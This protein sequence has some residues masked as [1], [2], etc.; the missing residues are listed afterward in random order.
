[1]SPGTATGTP[2]QDLAAIASRLAAGEQVADIVADVCARLRRLDDPA[3][4]IGDLAPDLDERVT[5]LDSLTAA[6]REDLALFGVP[7]VV[8]DNIDVAGMP[9]TAACRDLDRTPEASAAAVRRLLDAGAVLVA[10]V[11]LD[12]FATGL[13][14]TRS[15]YGTPRNV[16]DPAVVPGGSSSGSA[17]AVAAGIVPFALGTDTAGSGRVPAA[18]NQVVGV[19]PTRGTISTAGVVPAVA[20]MDCISV[21]CTSVADGVAIRQ[22]LDGPDRGDPWRRRSPSRRPLV[23]TDRLRVGVPEPEHLHDVDPAIVASMHRAIEA[24]VAAGAQTEPVDLTLLVETGR[25]LYDGALV[26]ERHASVGAFVES[27]PDSVVEPTRTIITRAAEWRATDLHDLQHRLL[28]RRDELAALWAGVDLLVTPTVPS[29]PTLAAV[30]AD[31]VG[32]NAEL[33]RFT[34]FSNLL[35]LAVLALPDPSAPAP[36]RGVSLQGPAGSDDLLAAAASVVLGVTPSPLPALGCV[37]LA[38]VGAHLDG[39][40]LNHQ[41]TDRGA[42]LVGATTTS[43]EYRLWAL[44]D[45]VRPALQRVPSGGAPIE[46]EVWS[47]AETELGGFAAGITAPLGLGTVR[48]RDGRSVLG[49]IVEDGGLGGAV[50]ITAARGWRAYRRG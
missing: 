50:D 2:V 34:T 33:G 45:G 30:A 22:L 13:V 43:A 9:T 7:F 26:A 18:M 39:E 19:K 44:P 41:L 49:F 25:Q 21:F 4:V 1:M 16:L 12:Q 6:E 38:V 32:A 11:N 3:L 14:G 36:G 37:D 31:P 48:L 17:V 40:A 46:V 47:I 5:A 15:P 27:H 35:D 10:K 8:K 23:R 28:A 24:L 20:S 42:A 29:A